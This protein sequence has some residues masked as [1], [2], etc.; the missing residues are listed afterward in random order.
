VAFFPTTELAKAAGFR[1]CLRCDPDAAGKKPDPQLAAIAA[2]SEFLTDHADERTRLKDIARA[3]GVP[4]LTILRGFKRV[5][6]VSPR[7]FA[8]AQRV[9][10]FKARVREPK[11]SVTTAIYDAGFGSS[12]RLYEDAGK[13]L[14]MTPTALKAGG[15]GETIRFA[16]AASPLGPMMVGATARGI[17]SVGF[18]D[19]EEELLADLQAKFPRAET[20]RMDR[21]LS[22]AVQAVV[23]AMAESGKAAALPLDIRATAFQLRVW[24][25]LEGIPRGETRTY[26]DIA[27]ALGAPSSVRA[28]ANA[29]A[30]NRLAVVIP[31]HR[32][33]GKDGSLTGYRWGLER[34]RALLALE[35]ATET[36]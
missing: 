4:P 32:V 34:K 15:A 1:A 19:S 30:S 23:A 5:L 29:I 11:A 12:S 36:A 28:V 7:E 21:E 33:V 20:K 27:T 9:A 22:Y 13:T 6:G 26:S 35:K 8:K 10:K 25:E 18:A 2:V 14:G 16:I 24:R 17:C 31:C 3:T